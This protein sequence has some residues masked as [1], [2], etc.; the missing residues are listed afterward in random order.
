MTSGGRGRKGRASPRAA[1]QGSE[2]ETDTLLGTLF[3]AHLRESGTSGLPE[4]FS[5]WVCTNRVIRP[6]SAQARQKH[7]ECRGDR[8]PVL[9]WLGGQTELSPASDFLDL[10]RRRPGCLAGLAERVYRARICSASSR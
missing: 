3:L 4:L 10:A 6:F 1:P 5:Q 9:E 7:V 2:G 8:L